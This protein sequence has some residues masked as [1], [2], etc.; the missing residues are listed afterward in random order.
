MPLNFF[1]DFLRD[2]V[3]PELGADVGTNDVESLRF[4]LNHRSI[5]ETL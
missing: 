4:L 1:H 3:G 2:E 5:G